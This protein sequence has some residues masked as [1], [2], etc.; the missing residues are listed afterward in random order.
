M[1]DGQ[2]IICKELIEEHW[3]EYLSYVKKRSDEDMELS[4]K[5]MEALKDIEPSHPSLGSQLAAVPATYEPGYRYYDLG[6]SG[7]WNW[8]ITTKI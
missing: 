5:R 6:I 4:K 3:L 1:Y 8:Y 7:F 2:P